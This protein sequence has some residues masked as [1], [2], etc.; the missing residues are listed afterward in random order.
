MSNDLKALIVFAAL[1]WLLLL[2]LGV[3]LYYHRRETNPYKKIAKELGIPWRIFNPDLMTEDKGSHHDPIKEKRTSFQR[4]VIEPM[5]KDMDIIPLRPV[6]NRNGDQEPKRAA[7]QPALIL[8]VK[9]PDTLLLY[10][11]YPDVAMTNGVVAYFLDDGRFL[12]AVGNSLEDALVELMHAGTK[13]VNFVC[14]VPVTIKGGKREKYYATWNQKSGTWAHWLPIK[15]TRYGPRSAMQ[16]PG[17][18]PTGSRGESGSGPD[19]ID[20]GAGGRSIPA[21]DDQN[22]KA[23][24][25]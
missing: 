24:D 20:G 14:V 4:R 21:R 7:S 23:E 18:V 13:N 16:Q 17:S 5:L 11:L 3:F 12:T 15:G 25:S 10:K 9:H 1:G 19:D 2:G 22:V 6:D 8:T